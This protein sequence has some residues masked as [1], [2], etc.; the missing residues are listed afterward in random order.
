MV[1]HRESWMDRLVNEKCCVLTTWKFIDF[2][3]NQSLA[4]NGNE[5]FVW[6]LVRRSLSY[7]VESRLGT[8]CGGLK[9]CSKVTKSSTQDLR[10]SMNRLG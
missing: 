1:V 2:H 3:V 7:G 5:R 10:P 8:W 6:A 9:L 4:T